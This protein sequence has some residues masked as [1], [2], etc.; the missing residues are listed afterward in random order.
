MTQ[1]IRRF[2]CVLLFIPRD[3]SYFK[4][5]FVLVLSGSYRERNSSDLWRDITGSFFFV[6]F[7][8]KVH[9]LVKSA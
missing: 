2:F 8:N 3:T 7:H 6:V 5:I 1:T 9:S 4:D